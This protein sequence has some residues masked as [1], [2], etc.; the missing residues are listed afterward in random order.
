MKI[1]ASLVFVFISFSLLAQYKSETFKEAQQSRSATLYVHYI[2]VPFFVQNKNAI[3]HGINM[4]IVQDFIEYVKDKKNIA[5]SLKTEDN[6]S[7]FKEMYDNIKK[8]TGL[9][10][11]MGTIIATEERK[12][13]IG[14]T[15]PY[16]TIYNVLVTHNEVPTLQKIQDISL[17]FKDL[18]GYTMK[19]SMMEKSLNELKNKYYPALNIKSF[20]SMSEA[21]N[22]T[23]SEPNSFGYFLLPNYINAVKSGNTLKR[24]AVADTEALP[25]SFLLPK[26]SDW[27]EV[28]DEFLNANGGYVNSGNY[29]SILTKNMGDT[30]IKLL[31]MHSN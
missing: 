24:H 20:S 27:I 12:R 14:M 6:S 22:K 29:K 1:K 23:I 3:P 15:K 25:V 26:N 17:H 28:F 4:E 18:T 11:G 30:G 8:G 10:L 16:I 21:I 7:N 13:E 19:G 5:I 2:E 31:K 9:V